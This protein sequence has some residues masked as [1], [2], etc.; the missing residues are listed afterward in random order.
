MNQQETK[1]TENM[2]ENMTEKTSHYTEITSWEDKDLNFL[3]NFVQ[4]NIEASGIVTSQ[5][6]SFTIFI[7]I[8]LRSL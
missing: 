4:I 8:S 3:G 2:S 6:A 1:R 7:K 5:P